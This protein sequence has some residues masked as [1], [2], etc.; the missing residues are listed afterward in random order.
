MDLDVFLMK[1]MHTMNN[2]TNTLQAS[3][4]VP[5]R[6]RGDDLRAARLT[7]HSDQNETERSDANI[8]KKMLFV[9]SKSSIVVL[10]Q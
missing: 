10:Q 3:R 8:Y 2:C 5:P 4:D 9:F 6:R 7:G 1:V